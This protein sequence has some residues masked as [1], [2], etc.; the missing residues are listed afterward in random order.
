MG[1]QEVT[2]ITLRNNGTLQYAGIGLNQQMLPVLLGILFAAAVAWIFLSTRLYAE[3]R[4]KHHSLYETLGCPKF[5]M[6][7]SLATNFKFIRYLIRRDYE[8]TGDPVVV[9][10]CQ[11]LLSLFYI[12]MICLAGCLLLIFE[13]II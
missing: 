6:P 8:A 7:K 13:K 1:M 12:Y 11:G 9:R 2:D 10:L 4:Q 5:F 3:L